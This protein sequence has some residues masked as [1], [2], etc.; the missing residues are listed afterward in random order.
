MQACINLDH[1]DVF[2]T[3]CVMTRMNQK[4]SDYAPSPH[5]S[6]FDWFDCAR[7]YFESSIDGY[8][9]LDEGSD[10]ESLY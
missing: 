8:S 4:L 1:S 5:S 3:T 2:S 9:L 10:C 6:F 7:P